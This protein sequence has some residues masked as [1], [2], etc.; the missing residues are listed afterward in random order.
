MTKKLLNGDAQ[1][2]G[3]M[4]SGGS[5]SIL[6][7][8]KTY[9]DYALEIRNITEPE[10]ILPQ[11]SHPAFLKACNYF[12]IKPVFIDVDIKSQKVLISEVKKK[13]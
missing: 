12:K 8:L 9:R 3:H 5:E 6:M 7:A 13:N 1:V 11:T 2:C 10:A 4:T